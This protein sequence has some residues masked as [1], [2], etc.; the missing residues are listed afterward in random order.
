MSPGNTVVVQTGAAPAAGRGPGRR[1][2]STALIAAVV[3]VLALGLIIVLALSSGGGGKTR[4]N[5]IIGTVAPTLVGAG[6]DGAVV[7]LD[8]FK[9]DWVLVNFF[10][11]WC[12][13]CI[14]EHPELIRLS[15][16]DGGPLQIISVGFQDSPKNVRK[17]F[18]DNGG[19]WPVLTGDTGSI[20]LSYGVVKLP[21]SFLV[22]PFGRVVAKF[23]GG[24]TAEMVRSYIDGSDAAGTTADEDPGSVS[25]GGGS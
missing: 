12:P 5:P 11:S 14:Q 24:V 10:A 17:F 2:R 23:E 3:G 9:G 7:S 6:L 4:R 21:E 22:S 18:D 20:G 15:K 13:P 25:D 19:N 16:D 8:S 1:R